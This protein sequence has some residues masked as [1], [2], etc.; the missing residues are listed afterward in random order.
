MDFATHVASGLDVQAFRGLQDTLKAAGD[1]Y[2]FRFDGALH[3]SALAQNKP[4]LGLYK[5][6]DITIDPKNPWQLETPLQPHSLFEEPGPRRFVLPC[7]LKEVPLFHS[8]WAPPV[9]VLPI[10]R[11]YR[12]ARCRSS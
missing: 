3:G 12:E 9:R 4:R 10:R 2:G 7:L 11:S 8:A 5:P 1:H 6:L